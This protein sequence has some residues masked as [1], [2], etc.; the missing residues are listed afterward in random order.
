MRLIGGNIL[1]FSIRLNTITAAHLIPSYFLTFPGK[2]HKRLLGDCPVLS[3]SGSC[4]KA[5]QQLQA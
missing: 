4:Y 5:C 1:D 2:P 3:D